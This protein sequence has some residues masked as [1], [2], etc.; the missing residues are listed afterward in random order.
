MN[1][2]LN[3]IRLF[4]IGL[5]VF[6]ITTYMLR[7]DNA[8]IAYEGVIG[9]SLGLLFGALLCGLDIFF[10]R[11]NLRSLNI[12]LIGLFV[13]YLLGK[14]LV[15]VFDEISH[16]AHFS[17]SFSPQT[18]DLIKT[19]IFLFSTY[20]STLMTLRGADEFYISIPFVRFASKMYKKRD[21]LLDSSAIADPRLY[22]LCATG[23][24]DHQL[25]LP[26]FIVKELYAQVEVSDETMSCK[27]RKALENIKRV[28][29]LESLGLRFNETDFPD[30]KEIHAKMYR[31]A[32]L[33]DAHILTADSGRVPGS[34]FDGIKTINLNSLSAALKPM[35]QAGE[36]I[37]IK[38]QRIG[39]EPRQGVGYL[40]DGTMVVINGGG[41]FLGE[42]VESRVL[43]VKHTSSG[44]MIFCNVLDDE[45]YE[46]EEE[47][48]V[49][50]EKS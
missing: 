38:V 43:S 39:K 17:N 18:I 49:S 3:F 14:A 40:E 6:F 36:I 13:G 30:V 4:F 16:I 28:Q 32:R 45:N 2:S 19:F 21:L 24:L 15:L 12:T 41:A 31:L 8:T 35:M 44:R 47:L 23:I 5:S 1:A 26:Q 9:I 11:F 25:I 50:H 7:G 48:E 29:S 33:H 20:I 42:V 27:A 46:K 34:A 37:R 10:R 22:D